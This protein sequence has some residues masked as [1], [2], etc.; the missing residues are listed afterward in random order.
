MATTRTVTNFWYH[1]DLTELVSPFGYIQATL[2][3][4]GDKRPLPQVLN[5]Y[6]TLTNVLKEIRMI[7]HITNFDF[8]QVQQGI[9]SC[10]RQLSFSRRLSV[11]VRIAPNCVKTITPT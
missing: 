3:T 11:S 1:F 7:R 10:I 8:A 9:T 4:Q 6:I 5:E 2:D